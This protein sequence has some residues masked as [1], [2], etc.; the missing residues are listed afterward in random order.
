MIKAKFR[1]HVRSKTDTAMKNE[2]LGKILCHNIVCLIHAIHELKIQPVFEI[3][4]H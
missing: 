1:D 3:G 2:V 4:G